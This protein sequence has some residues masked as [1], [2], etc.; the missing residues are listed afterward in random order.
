[1]PKTQ[2]GPLEQQHQQAQH[3]DPPIDIF[4]TPDMV[5][6]MM[7]NTAEDPGVGAQVGAIPA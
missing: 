3:G 1:M 5:H 7:R 4:S 2:D 6:T